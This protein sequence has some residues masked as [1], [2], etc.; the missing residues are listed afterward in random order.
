M[1]EEWSDVGFR[2][3]LNHMPEH[4]PLAR[5]GSMERVTA[6][7]EWTLGT[8]ERRGMETE[9]P[10]FL[11]HVLKTYDSRHQTL[12]QFGSRTIPLFA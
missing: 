10:R 6:R 1:S 2:V 11:F 3:R 5:A 7:G 9:D 4:N 12:P 8:W